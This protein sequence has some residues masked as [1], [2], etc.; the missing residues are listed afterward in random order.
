LNQLVSQ[1][2][3]DVWVQSVRD[4]Y[5]SVPYDDGVHPVTDPSRLAAIGRLFGIRA[6]DPRECRVLELG[7]GQGTNLL[8]LAER[9]PGSRFLG[10]DFSAPQIAAG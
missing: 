10:L 9:L 7:C 5:E 8:A 1:E 6:A 2:K 3:T 4:E